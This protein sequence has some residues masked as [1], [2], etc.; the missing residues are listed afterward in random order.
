MED[1]PFESLIEQVRELHRL[2]DELTRDK[3]R[4][5]ENVRARLRWDDRTAPSLPRPQRDIAD[6]AVEILSKPRLSTSQSKSLYRAF[7]GR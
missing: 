4:L 1:A 5:E 6:Q 7:F 3:S 2:A